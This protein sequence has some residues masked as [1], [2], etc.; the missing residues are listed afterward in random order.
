MRSDALAAEEATV[1]ALDGILA[2]LDTVK[3]DVDLAFVGVEGDAEVDD[4]AVLALAFGFDVVLKFLLP[5]DGVLSRFSVG[6]V[7]ARDVRKGKGR[8]AL[9]L[10]EHVLEQDAAA[11]SRLLDWCLLRLNLDGNLGLWL[12]GSS[13]LAHQCITAVVGEV[14]T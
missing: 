11:R 14:D 2:A 6:R 12:V 4:D 5:V 9:S 3:L 8:Y 1:Q 13:K 7:L 10:V